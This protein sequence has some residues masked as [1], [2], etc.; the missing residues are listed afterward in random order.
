MA[1]HMAVLVRLV[2]AVLM[3][4]MDQVALRG[5]RAP[6]ARVVVAAQVELREYLILGKGSGLQHLVML[7][8]TV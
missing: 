5:H 7:S 3:E 4:R 8:M 2:R 6:Q 1:Q